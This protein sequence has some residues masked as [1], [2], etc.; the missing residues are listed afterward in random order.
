MLRSELDVKRSAFTQVRG[1]AFTGADV[2]RKCLHASEEVVPSVSVCVCVCLCLSVR[3]YL[4]CVRASSGH[5]L[6]MLLVMHKIKSKL[7]I[8]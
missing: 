2:R 5:S 1:Y 4:L 3:I 8:N 6:V 7:Q